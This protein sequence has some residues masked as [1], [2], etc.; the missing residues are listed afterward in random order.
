MVAD[1][2]IAA[3]TSEELE[4]VE[5]DEGENQSEHTSAGSAS[6]PSRRKASS[7]SSTPP[8]VAPE[9]KVGDAAGSAAG[10]QQEAEEV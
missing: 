7:C 3:P 9:S 4:A 10:Y 6:M 8:S 1:D 5:D 2:P